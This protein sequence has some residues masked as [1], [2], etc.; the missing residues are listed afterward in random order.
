MAVEA[1]FKRPRLKV[2]SK[3]EEAAAARGQ[4]RW[5]CGALMHQ[6]ATDE[7]R[8][9]IRNELPD[10]SIT[11]KLGRPYPLVLAACY[12][13]MDKGEAPTPDAVALALADGDHLEEAG[14]RAE[15]WTMKEE[16][17]LSVEGVRFVAQKVA[18]RLASF[19]RPAPKKA[20]KRRRP[21]STVDV[22]DGATATQVELLARI[23]AIFGGYE[24]NDD[25]GFC[26]VHF[27]DRGKHL[28]PLWPARLVPK[29]LDQVL[30]FSGPLKTRIRNTESSWA[31]SRLGGGDEE[32]LTLAADDI[33][34]KTPEWP[35]KAGHI[36]GPK[37]G[38]VEET[39]WA[40]HQSAIEAANAHLVPLHFAAEGTGL[41]ER[42]GRRMFLAPGLG[43]IHAGGIDEGW[44][45][46]MV[47]TNG[48]KLNYRMLPVNPA[49]EDSDLR[50]L[51]GL[52]AT[53][54]DSAAGLM[55]VAVLCAAPL[56]QLVHAPIVIVHGRSGTMKTALAHC[57]SAAMAPQVTGI[58]P[59]NGVLVAMRPNDTKSSSSTPGLRQLLHAGGGLPV[60]GDDIL[61]SR[62]G[63][64][65]IQNAYGKLSEIAGES[66]NGGS[67][68]AA[69]NHGNQ[70]A[71]EWREP[72][73]LFVTSAEDLHLEATPSE[74]F[75]ARALTVLVRPGNID[76]GLLRKYQSEEGAAAL[77]RALTSHV[78]WLMARLDDE[79]GAWREEI[80]QLAG[81]WVEAAGHPRAAAGWAALAHGVRRLLLQMGALD[82][83]PEV[84]ER[85]LQAARDHALTTG[86]GSSGALG[87]EGGAEDEDGPAPS[88][89]TWLDYFRR[90][91]SSGRAEFR[92]SA[93]ESV[94][95]R[96][97]EGRSSVP[98][99]PDGFGPDGAG[100][101]WGDGYDGPGWRPR[102]Q[103]E[104]L[105]GVAR[106][107][108]GRLQLRCLR[109]A[110]HDVHVRI[111]KLARADG[112]S[113]PGEAALLNELRDRGWLWADQGHRTQKEGL[114]GKR[115]RVYV[116]DWAALL[117]ATRTPQEEGPQTDPQEPQEGPQTDPQ[118]AP[119]ESPQAGP[120]GLQAGPQEPQAGPQEG[121]P[122][123]AEGLD[124]Q[125]DWVAE[126]QGTSASGIDP[127][128]PS[129]SD[130][131]VAD[132]GPCPHNRVSMGA[133]DARCE[134][135]GATRG[136]G[137][138]WSTDPDPDPDPGASPDPAPRGPSWPRS[139]PRVAALDAGGRL[140][141]ADGEVMGERLALKDAI[142]RVKKAAEEGGPKVLYLSR[143][144]ADELGVTS[145]GRSL[146][147]AP[148]FAKTG[149]PLTAGKRAGLVIMEGGPSIEVPSPS[150]PW[151]EVQGAQELLSLLTEFMRRAGT[152]WSGPSSTV[153]RM[154]ERSRV[155]L[156]M[157]DSSTPPKLAVDGQTQP[158]MPGWVR[159]PTDDEQKLPFVVAF[160]R[161]RAFLASEGS[162]LLG[163]GKC[164]PT[165]NVQG[166]ARKAVAEKAGT[167]GGAGLFEVR[168]LE[169]R[170]PWEVPD[171]R[172]VGRRTAWVMNPTLHV[173]DRLGLPYE[174][175]AAWGYEHSSRY[176]RPM[177]EVVSRN[178][179]ETSG[180]LRAAFKSLYQALGGSLADH[181]FDSTPEVAAYRP[182][183]RHAI[184]AQDAAMN[185]V[186]YARGVRQHCG[187]WPLAQ[188]V[189][190]LAFAVRA[191]SHEDAARELGLPLDDRDGHYKPEG[192]VPMSTWLKIN[193]R[194]GGAAFDLI[195]SGR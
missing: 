87:I 101:D 57:A 42:A 186:H 39:G 13:L 192:I 164:S 194:T 5:A 22:E 188:N 62:M 4:L 85:F 74:S 124:L 149:L 80:H 45:V 145:N 71:A 29:Q 142:L 61:L 107:R 7:A 94:A 44:S 155:K 56:I 28:Q 54:G 174:V 176:L 73:G 96:D 170:E 10:P 169:N 95:D 143:A 159:P 40:L 105:G 177:A 106:T 150:S 128:R 134:D 50:H 36:G 17:C 187:R 141:S 16:D 89:L 12:A 139:T 144:A 15:L 1:P 154:A 180:P 97:G 9:E 146:E 151:F 127:L 175:K 68:R 64:S 52:A 100:W 129:P 26:R 138:R 24:F 191:D 157:D 117:G 162:V 82:Q 173:L 14:G 122:D 185:F 38:D 136:P 20:A 27:D 147:L 172:L 34:A 181:R 130:L 90:L 25:H 33:Y 93:A 35:S 66:E 78:C 119:Q 30:F 63:P 120:Q 126:G 76:R 70:R 166:L 189:D 118:A 161:N 167:G 156:T 179:R 31:L 131:P 11:E 163:L 55:H 92:V 49:T 91:L 116:L 46:R 77:S 153:L 135:C 41:V 140:L 152:P 132:R 67:V 65:A 121:W 148:A 137:G 72:R 113:V 53:S 6:D 104:L 160:D 60:H 123:W 21:S 125:T 168:L 51:L 112:R 58:D 193:P 81:K 47:E 8:R 108:D 59:R 98:D 165:E 133:G 19:G 43:G 190:A 195:R 158:A 84:E 48:D 99:M 32:D 109:S 37:P 111:E 69:H 23:N 79:L 88:V 110:F 102:P 114:W 183:W 75:W 2:L 178:I 182:D 171:R 3:D 184:I 18:E 115:P 83:W 103:T 86:L